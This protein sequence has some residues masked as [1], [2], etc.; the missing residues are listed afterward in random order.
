[1]NNKKIVLAK[2]A[3]WDPWISF[4]WGRATN[5]DIWDLINPDSEVKP[6][7]LSI[8][9]MPEYVMPANDEDFNIVTYNAYKARKEIYKTKLALYK[10]QRNLFGNIISFIQ[11]TVATHNVIFFQKEEAHPWNYL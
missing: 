2:P 3:N 1:M 10:K 5:N 7:C 8:Q 6:L 9:T 11:E 4:I